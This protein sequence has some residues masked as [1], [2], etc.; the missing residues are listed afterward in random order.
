MLSLLFY[1]EDVVLL[2]IKVFKIFITLLVT[3]IL[4]KLY[5]SGFSIQVVTTAGVTVIK[6][7][8]MQDTTEMTLL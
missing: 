1:L 3:K 7:F 6:I 8:I 5:E 4:N 2:L